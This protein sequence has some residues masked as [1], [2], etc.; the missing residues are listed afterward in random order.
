LDL[1]ER[2]RMRFDFY[3]PNTIGECIEMLT[4]FGLKT[5]LLAGGTDLLVKLRLRHIRPQA[6]ISLGGID[7]LKK[8][9]RKSDGSLEIG[10]MKT[11]QEVESSNLLANEFDLVRQGAGCVSSIQVRNVA[12][13]GGNSCNASSSADTV[14]ALIA[15][16]AEVQIVG[17]QGERHLVLEDFFAGP[18]ETVLQKGEILTEFK[19]PAPS[20]HSGGTYKKY[21]IRGEVDISIVGVATRLT[22]DRNHKLQEV[23]IVLGG[24]APT[25]IRVRRAEDM[26]V[27]QDP[28]EELFEE[29][30]QLA[31]EESRPIS[32]Q[33]ATAQYRREMVK[34]WTR[35]TLQETFQKIREAIKAR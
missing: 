30:A 25:P 31:A 12:T 33:R 7:E 8:L 19:L 24:V 35:Y 13:L 28:K 16:G 32:D 5:S 6:V 3:E 11:L 1:L 15:L 9:E 2:K 17:P 23:R 20:S 22:L 21:A 10:A 26:L 29:A 18:G 34:V 4:H 14:P 27:G